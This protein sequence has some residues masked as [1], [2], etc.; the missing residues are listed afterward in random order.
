M[1]PVLEMPHRMLLEDNRAI[2]GRLWKRI[3]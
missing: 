3:A 1:T 2:A